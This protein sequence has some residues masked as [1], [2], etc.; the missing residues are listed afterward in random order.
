[1]SRRATVTETE[2]K[3]AL[4]AATERGLSVSEII[5]TADCVRLKIGSVDEN[6]KPVEDKA[7]LAWPTR[8]P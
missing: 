8:T 3:R 1:M 5:M 7:P 4:K 2:L 6:E